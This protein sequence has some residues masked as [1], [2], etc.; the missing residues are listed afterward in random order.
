MIRKVVL[1][2]S[3]SEHGCRGRL[4]DLC[5]GRLPIPALGSTNS[6]SLEP[7]VSGAVFRTGSGTGS[8]TVPGPNTALLR[9]RLQDR[10]L[11]AGM[12]LS[13]L[14]LGCRGAVF[15][16]VS[17]A[18]SG[19]VDQS[20]PQRLRPLRG[21]RWPSQ[22]PSPGPWGRCLSPA[23]VPVWTKTDPE[24]VSSLGTDKADP[25]PATF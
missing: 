10:R 24:P 15:G 12:G 4:R 11:T 7:Y 9:A 5:R 22:R 19:T 17:G 6:T 14:S 2:V 16:T 13:G 3:V 18:A 21:P 20:S 23:P 1:S 25:K 8:R